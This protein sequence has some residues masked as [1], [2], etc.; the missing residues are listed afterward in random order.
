MHRLVSLKFM[1]SISLIDDI[2]IYV[3]VHINILPKYV[4]TAFSVYIIFLHYM[5]SR[6]TTLYYIINL[7]VHPQGR[8]FSPFDLSIPQL[9]LILYLE[10]RLQEIPFAFSV[11]IG[12]IIVQA[13][14]GHFMRLHG[15]SSLTRV[16]DR[17]S[18]QA[19][20]PAVSRTLPTLP[21]SVIPEPWIQELC[22]RCYQLGL[23]RT[24]PLFLAFDEL[25]LSG[26]ISICFKQM[27]L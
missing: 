15:Y 10:L 16:G 22:C 5:V 23:D 20:Y 18:Q 12:V 19:S 1:A 8:L 17:T 4:N 24:W 25:W 9:P 21:S 26:M 6:L 7:G 14:L 11:S 2:Q 13:F 27:F 3:C